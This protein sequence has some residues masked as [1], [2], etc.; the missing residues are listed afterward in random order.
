MIFPKPKF[1]LGDKVTF[2]RQGSLLQVQFIKSAT[3]VGVAWCGDDGY[4]YRLDP[5]S[6]GLAPREDELS[7]SG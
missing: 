1:N 6:Y 3:I 5:P 7:P 4:Q 2:H